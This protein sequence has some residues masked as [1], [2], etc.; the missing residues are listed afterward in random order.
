MTVNQDGASRYSPPPPYERPSSSSS[1]SDGHVKYIPLSEKT[2]IE[3]TMLEHQDPNNPFAFTTQQLNDMLERRNMDFVHQLGGIESFA[4]GLHSSTAHGI[5]DTS[6]PLPVITLH[7]LTA[8]A[9]ATTT[10]SSINN[11]A[12]RKLPSAREQRNAVFGTNVLPQIQGVSIM[13]LMRASL[14][15]KTLVKLIQCDRRLGFILIGSVTTTDSLDN[16]S[17][18]VAGRR[19]V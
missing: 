13:Q 19:A 9:T 8:T 16:C 4:R 3:L 17:H 10:P 7:N 6:D 18:G 2:T 11:N 15:D 1:E 12:S 5:C 14:Q